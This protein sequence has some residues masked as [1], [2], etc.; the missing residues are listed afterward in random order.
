MAKGSDQGK[1]SFKS[2]SVTY[3]DLAG[4][5]GAVHVNLEG[6]ATGFGTVLGTMSLFGDAPGA[7]SGRSSWVGEAYLPNGDVVQGTGD[8]F[9]EKSGKHKW[10]VRSVVRTSNGALLLSDGVISLDGRSYKGKLTQWS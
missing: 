8:G 3:E 7:Q 6:E 5:G 4:G 2:T 1:F 9:Y 10:R